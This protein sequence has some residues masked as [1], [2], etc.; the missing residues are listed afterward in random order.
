VLIDSILSGL[1]QPSST[2][3]GLQRIAASRAVGAPEAVRAAEPVRSCGNCGA[4]ASCRAAGASAAG[5]VEVDIVELTG[6]TASTTAAQRTDEAAPATATRRSG[7]AAPAAATR[8][9]DEP[10]PAGATR[11]YEE[12]TAEEQ[13]EVDELKQRDREVRQHEAAHLAAA[14]QYA[15]GGATYSMKTGPDGNQY[16]VGGEVQID[17]SPVKG[18]PEATI[19]KMQVVRAAALAPA[20]PSTQDRKIAAQAD[21]EI[22][23]AQAEL[24]RSRA[25]SGELGTAAAVSENATAAIS[26]GT[27]TGVGEGAAVA[28]SKQAAVTPSAAVPASAYD[29]RGRSTQP[30]PAA[31]AASS[32]GSSSRSSEAA[33]SS[34]P[35]S[36]L[37]PQRIESAYGANSAAAAPTRPAL[38]LL[39]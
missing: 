7:E 4:C 26:E 36:S 29:A 13:A 21:A 32:T 18:D 38:S 25:Q 27:P 20:E 19:A 15:R 11:R 23:K 8:R 6:P 39:A 12:L 30:Q 17:T 3:F 28:V 31:F 22:R 10:P 1:I 34:R 33:S 14:G 16:A 2:G 9:N 35:R 5:L 24:A 37:T